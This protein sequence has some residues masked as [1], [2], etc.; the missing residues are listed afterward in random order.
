MR[1]IG[2]VY[3]FVICFAV[4]GFSSRWTMSEIPG[5][6]QTLMRPAIAPPNWIF[7][8]VWTLLYALMAIAAWQVW[9]L[10]SSP[11]RSWGMALFLA[12]LALNFAWTWIFFRQHAIGAALVELVLLWIAIGVTA[13]VFGR[14]A[15]VA[16]WLLAPY[17][18]WVSFAAVLNAAYW[19]L[20]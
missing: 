4:A 9:Q 15:P 14:V 20:N 1:W 16:A 19:R 10:P 12:Q 6:Y 3:W 17:W 2:L 5:W 13:L 8:P 7:G 18:A 11:L